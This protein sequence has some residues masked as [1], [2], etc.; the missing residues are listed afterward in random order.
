MRKNLKEKFLAAAALAAFAVFAP[1]LVVGPF[2]ALAAPAALA[3]EPQYKPPVLS[4]PI[5]T[6]SFSNITV[7]QQGEKKIID[8]PYLAEYISGVY[9]Y[10]VGIASVIAAVMMMVGG[11]QYLTAGGDASKVAAGKERISNAVVGLFLSLGVYVVLYAVNPD[12]VA[13]R[14]LRIEQVKT[15]PYIEPSESEP[16]SVNGS[17]A[18]SFKAPTGK[19]ITGPGKS[20]VPTELSQDL[21]EAAAELQAQNGYGMLIGSS[22]RTVERQIELIKENC[23]NPPGS[24]SCNPK[25]DKPTTC[26]L[27]DN[28]PA[29]CPHTTGRALDI[30]ATKDGK[31][32]ISRKECLADIDGCFAN[33]CQAALIERMKDAGFCVLS[34]EP[35][36][37]EKPKMSSNC[38]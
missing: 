11:F 25:P 5:P 31:Q 19:N 17:I 7:T 9:R 35:W 26:I 23:Q 18:T 16:D 4:V 20:K 33:E 15:I 12:L 14:G 30:W 21:T 10:A 38:K 22:L 29:N 1:A 2:G 3:A 6:V 8:V 24:A 13:L 27:K 34:S 28:N 37:F 32:C 36:H